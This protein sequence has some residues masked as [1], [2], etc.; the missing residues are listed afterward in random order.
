M[1]GLDPHLQ[2]P[3]RLKL[4]SMLAA[5]SEMEFSTLRDEL[6][7]SDAPQATSQAPFQPI[8]A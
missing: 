6:D 1:L 5:V 7:V 4:M 8:T 3:A 2:A